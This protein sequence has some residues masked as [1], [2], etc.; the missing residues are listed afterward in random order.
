MGWYLVKLENVRSTKAVETDPQTQVEL[1]LL[2]APTPADDA[3]KKALDKEFT[4]TTARLRKGFEVKAYF[5]KGDFGKFEASKALGWIVKSD[6]EPD[7]AKA[8][9]GLK[10]GQWS[11][12]VTVNGTTA[13]VYMA[14]DKQAMPAKL[15]EY[16]E[17]VLNSIYGNRVELEARRFMQNLRQR[18]FLDVRL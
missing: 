6:L 18:A 14:D 3:G 7:L 11:D 10:P 1:Y 16:R 4:K 8:V 2:A 17:R 5:D 12:N 13:R 9:E 15:A